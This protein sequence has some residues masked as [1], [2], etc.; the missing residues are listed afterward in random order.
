MKYILF[1]VLTLS[2]CA[3]HQGTDGRT[4]YWIKPIPFNSSVVPSNSPSVQFYQGTVNGT[5]YQASVFK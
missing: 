1:L 4:Y 5:A 3:T 2:G